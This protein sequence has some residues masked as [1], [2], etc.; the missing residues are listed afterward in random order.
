MWLRGCVSKLV[1]DVTRACRL[2]RKCAAAYIEALAQVSGV[3]LRHALLDGTVADDVDD[4]ADLVLLKV[5][6]EGDHAPLLE[7]AREG[8][9]QSQPLVFSIPKSSASLL[10]MCRVSSSI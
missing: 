5:G 7:V 4:V 2:C 10:V 3:D 9:S 8:C 6:G 1:V